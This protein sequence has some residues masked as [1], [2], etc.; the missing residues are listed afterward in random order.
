MGA[1]EKVKNKRRRNKEGEGWIKRKQQAVPGPRAVKQQL[2]WQHVTHDPIQRC[3][4]VRVDVE[5]C[6]VKRKRMNGA[7]WQSRLG[8]G[9]N[10]RINT[11]D[12]RVREFSHR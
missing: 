12:P 5:G 7:K 11:C 8:N 10:G 1:R 6:E 2:L 3:A 4:H 9:R